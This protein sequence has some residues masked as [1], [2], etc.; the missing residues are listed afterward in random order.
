VSSTIDS[1]LD[2]ARWLLDGL[3]KHL[4]RLEQYESEPRIRAEFTTGFLVYQLLETSG[5]ISRL[6][7][8]LEAA[9]NMEEVRAFLEEQRTVGDEVKRALTRR[10]HLEELTS[11][12]ACERF[13]QEIREF[14]RGWKQDSD[15]SVID[16]RDIWIER[17]QLQLVIDG[18]VEVWGAAAD[19]P[20]AKAKAAAREADELIRQNLAAFEPAGPALEEFKARF[21]AGVSPESYWWWH[22]GLFPALKS[23]LP[24][25]ELRGETYPLRATGRGGLFEIQGLTL[26][27]LERAK[28]E[29]TE[30]QLEWAPQDA[31]GIKLANL[32]RSLRAAAV[33]GQPTESAPRLMYSYRFRGRSLKV[34]IYDDD[35][36]FLKTEG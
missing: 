21:N 17:D 15:E 34:L 9:T 31:I 26:A 18:A 35:R 19:V 1:S 20:L 7:S 2:Q 29:G 32:K 11:A 30:A 4:G 3:R 10:R 27:H 12:L 16:A 22:A 14:L 33:E 8:A 13:L 24:R 28:K 25:L 5:M 6:R 23:G 36:I